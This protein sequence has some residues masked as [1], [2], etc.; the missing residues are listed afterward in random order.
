MSRSLTSSTS[1]IGCWVKI[2]DPQ[3]AVFDLSAQW[4]YDSPGQGFLRDQMVPGQWSR[5]S[6]RFY[7]NLP[8]STS[9][10]AW[11]GISKISVRGPSLLA[12][13]ETDRSFSARALVFRQ[14]LRPRRRL[15]GSCNMMPGCLRA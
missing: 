1:L 3:T 14:L 7:N 5:V 4:A 15:I 2:D 10:Q 12:L 9:M 13:P 6:W 8:Y 11:F